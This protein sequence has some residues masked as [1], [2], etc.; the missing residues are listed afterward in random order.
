M[1]DLK[2]LR[3]AEPPLFISYSNSTTKY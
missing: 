2:Q 1:I 3:G